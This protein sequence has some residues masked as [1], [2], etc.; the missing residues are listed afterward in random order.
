MAGWAWRHRGTLR[1]AGDLAVRTPVMLRE[2][3]TPELATE[4]RAVLALDATLPKETSVRIS[5][6]DAGTVT[7][8]GDPG[9]RAVTAVRTALLHVPGVA[10]VRSDGSTLPTTSSMLSAA[11][12]RA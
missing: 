8:H 4:A 2:G 7:L 11:P 3:R 6:I 12:A 5:G 9:A 1:R 10:D